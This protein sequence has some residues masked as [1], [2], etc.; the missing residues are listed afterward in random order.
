[1]SKGVDADQDEVWPPQRGDLRSNFGPL[2]PAGERRAGLVE[3]VHI[4]VRG[5]AARPRSTRRPRTVG[6][7]IAVF[8][9][10]VVEDLPRVR[11]PFRVKVVAVGTAKDLG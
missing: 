8:V 1:G 5:G 4:Q 9:D 6:D 10:L 3:R 2:A 11:S 7:A